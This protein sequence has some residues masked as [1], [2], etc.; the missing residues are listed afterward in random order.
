MCHPNTVAEWP[1][2]V[3]VL[4]ANPTLDRSS[5]S[6][7]GRTIEGEA[8]LE[9]GDPI[10]RHGFLHSLGKRQE[11]GL[12]EWGL[13]PLLFQAQYEKEKRRGQ[14]STGATGRLTTSTRSQYP[15]HTGFLACHP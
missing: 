1:L 9:G 12:D 6:C 2:G 15:T 10:L 13:W 4:M 8:N 5:K 14:T 3:L 7:E 11:A